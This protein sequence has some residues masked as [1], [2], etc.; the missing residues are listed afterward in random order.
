M[1]LRALLPVRET[2]AAGKGPV[3]ALAAGGIGTGQ[4]VLMAG[5][6]LAPT[7]RVLDRVLPK[8]GT[9]PSAAA[10]RKGHFRSDIYTTTIRRSPVPEHGGR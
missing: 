4:G 3:G 2:M 6:A 10:R 5:M 8:P 7:R 9:G 1:V